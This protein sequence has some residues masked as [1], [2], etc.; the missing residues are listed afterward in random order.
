MARSYWVSLVTIHCR[1]SDESGPIYAS[2]IEQ[3]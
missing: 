2:I 3:P 1:L